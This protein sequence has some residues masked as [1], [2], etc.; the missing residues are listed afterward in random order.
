MIREEEKKEIESRAE[1]ATLVRT[2]YGHIRKEETLGPIFNGI[3]D[4][5][6][7]HLE[8]L[9]DFWEMQLLHNRKYFGNPMTAHVSVDKKEN[10][11]VEMRHFGIWLNLWYKTIDE[12]F[13]GQIAKNAKH[14]ARMMSTNLFLAIFRHRPQGKKEIDL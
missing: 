1:V 12:N 13:K 9:T 2:F 14:K 7:E 10:N 8:R 6:E 3:I 5:W 11:T 4:D